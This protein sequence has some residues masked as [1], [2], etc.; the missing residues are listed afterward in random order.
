MDHRAD[1]TGTP[2]SFVYS[3]HYYA[4]IGRH[5]FP[6]EKFPRLAERLVAEGVVE[7]DGFLVPEEC[8]RA[9]L[10]LVHTPEYVDDLL[11]FRCTEA[12]RRSELPIHREIVRAHTVGAGGTVLACERAL[13]QGAAMNLT[14]GFHHCFPD[15][16]EGFCYVND[17]AVAIRKMQKEGRIEKACVIDCDLHQGNGTAFIFRDDGSVF[18]FSIHQE[19][20]YPAK[21]KSDLDIGL[22]DGVGD[23]EYLSHLHRVLPFILD[24]VKPDL[25]LYQAGVDP[26]EDDVLGS[27]RLTRDGLGQRDRLVMTQCKEREIPLAVVVGGGYAAKMEDTVGLHFGTCREL[28]GVRT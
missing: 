3:E 7:P 8:S 20:L 6:T 16:A 5:V 13:E 28:A 23:E 22:D 26:F 21:Q 10:L 27:L 17:L 24:D 1:S 9:D 14:G 11:A 18:T 12:T 19:R 4:D 15:H 25:V 2:I